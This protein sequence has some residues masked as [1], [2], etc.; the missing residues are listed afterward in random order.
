MKYDQVIRVRLTQEQFHF[1]KGHAQQNKVDMSQMIRNFIDK[2]EREERSRQKGDVKMS[3]IYQIK[4]ESEIIYE[5]LPISTLPEMSKVM[6]DFHNSI[7][8]RHGVGENDDI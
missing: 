5:V 2:L 1:L 6:S 7:V 3:G 8:R 4:K